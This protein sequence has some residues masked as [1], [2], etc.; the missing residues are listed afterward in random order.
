MTDRA[1]ARYAFDWRDRDDPN[2]DR[3]VGQRV[4][5]AAMRCYHTS[6]FGRLDRFETGIAH[7]H[8]RSFLRLRRLCGAHLG[9]QIGPGAGHT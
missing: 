8:G 5:A 1:W 3:S 7:K 2:N 9:G 4:G 6:A